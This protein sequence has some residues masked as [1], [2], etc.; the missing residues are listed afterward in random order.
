MVFHAGYHEVANSQES[1]EEAAL[2]PEESGAK[3]L[4]FTRLFFDDTL[5]PQLLY[6]LIGIIYVHVQMYKPT[7]RDPAAK[8]SASVR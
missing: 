2:E 5:G 7:T 8:V 4:P 1:E 6:R 3:V